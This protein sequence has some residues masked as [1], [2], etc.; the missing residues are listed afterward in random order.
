MTPENTMHAVSD[1]AAVSASSERPARSFAASRS[2]S[3][4]RAALG[5]VALAGV[6]L[7][8]G[9]TPGQTALVRGAAMP[10]RQLELAQLKEMKAQP[11]SKLQGGVS[12]EGAAATPPA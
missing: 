4:T 9:D 5:A 6:T 10:R 2:A 3:W 12:T 1:S 8:A 7:A 11:V